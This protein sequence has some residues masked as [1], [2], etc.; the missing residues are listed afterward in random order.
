MSCNM[1]FE[2]L[3]VYVQRVRSMLS[4]RAPL[5]LLRYSRYVA[6]DVGEYRILIR[7]GVLLTKAVVIWTDILKRFACH[8]YSLRLQ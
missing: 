8:D 2:V 3:Y 1:C 7:F 6:H 4:W 5:L